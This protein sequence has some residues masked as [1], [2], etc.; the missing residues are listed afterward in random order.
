MFLSSR[1]KVGLLF[2]VS[3][4]LTM[5]GT[6]MVTSAL[7]QPSVHAGSV[8]NAQG[9]KFDMVPSSPDI[10][11]CLPHAQAKVEIIRGSVNQLM[12]VHVKGLAPNAGFALFV[13]EIPNKPFGISW[14]QSDMET[15]GEGE[16]SVNVRGIFDVETFS[17]SQGGPTT[18]FAPTH[19]Y[20]LG[21]WFGD[22]QTP[23][24]L[25]CEPGATQ[26]IVTPFD[27]DQEAGPQVLNTS[28]FPD[29]AGPLSHVQP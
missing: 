13:I 29:N 5:V 20:H 3:I 11:A 25:G 23:F 1:S 16:S 26:P 4:L 14:Y 2:T 19:Q 27:G 18:T 15:N 8:N 22:P 28:N 17:L 7:Q 24:K 12:T 9:F 6:F 21:I 10:K